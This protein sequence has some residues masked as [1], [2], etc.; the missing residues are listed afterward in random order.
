MHYI[1]DIVHFI[2]FL[3]QCRKRSGIF[4]LITHAHLKVNAVF[5]IY[6]ANSSYR[7]QS[8][9]KLKN[10]HISFK[11]LKLQKMNIFSKIS[12]VHLFV[13]R[14]SSFAFN[15]TLV[16]CLIIF[17]SFSVE[18]SSCLNSS[19]TYKRNTHLWAFPGLV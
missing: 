16:S 9:G 17:I 11:K 6:W 10:N 3:A 13:V 14:Q 1:E 19:N 2:T 7:I 5:S 4:S 12:F 15:W 8:G 18:V